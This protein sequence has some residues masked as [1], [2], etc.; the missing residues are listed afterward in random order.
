[1][2]S[3]DRAEMEVRPEAR[4][5]WFAAALEELTAFLLSGDAFRPLSRLPRGTSLDLSLGGLLLAWD[6]LQASESE[7]SPS[8]RA[9]WFRLR[10]RWDEERRRNAAAID[11]KASAELPNRFN[12]W[13]AYLSDLGE[14]PDEVH[15]YPTEV[16]NRVVI[17]RLSQAMEPRASPAGHGLADLDDLLRAWFNIGQFIWPKS[18]ASVYPLAEFWFLYGAPDPERIRSQPSGGSMLS[19]APS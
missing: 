3:T 17:A 4:L 13:R 16:R 19:G 12:L 1:M 10:A 7:L 18:L 5:A 8:A 15:G 11:R 2:R 9:E 6:A 14:K